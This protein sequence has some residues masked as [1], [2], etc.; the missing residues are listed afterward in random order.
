MRKVRGLICNYPRA[1][2][3]LGSLVTAQHSAHYSEL[4]V[5]VS[6]SPQTS[7]MESCVEGPSWL[8]CPM[9]ARFPL[10]VRCFCVRGHL[11]Q[12]HAYSNSDAV[13]PSLFSPPLEHELVAPQKPSCLC[14]LSRQGD[15]GLYVACAIIP[16]VPC[17][18]TLLY[19]VYSDSRRLDFVTYF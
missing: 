8:L 15:K 19:F 6:C 4:S 10:K 7:E 12:T 11:F 18:S 17:T 13:A 3:K 9:L 1:Q 16:S 2:P 14:P 5:D